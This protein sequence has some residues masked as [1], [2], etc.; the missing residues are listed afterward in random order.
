MGLDFFKG[1]N[2]EFLK[3]GILLVKFGRIVVK[4]IAK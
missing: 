1:L 4:L 3:V 2:D